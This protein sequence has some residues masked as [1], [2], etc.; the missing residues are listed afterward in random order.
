MVVQFVVRIFHSKVLCLA[1]EDR[2]RFARCTRAAP[3]ESRSRH[4]GRG[5]PTTQQAMIEKAKQVDEHVLKESKTIKAMMS[6]VQ[7]NTKLRHVRFGLGSSQ[8]SKETGLAISDMLQQT[9][10]LESI[11]VW[12]LRKS[13]AQR[14]GI[15]WH[16][17]GMHCWMK[18]ATS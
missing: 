12:H 3:K 14:H 11:Q 1:T 17:S 7:E 18:G 5:T 10:S 15:V 9:T 4:G 6:A 8:V 13:W 2:V 16:T